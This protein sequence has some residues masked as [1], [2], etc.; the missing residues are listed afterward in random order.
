MNTNSIAKAVKGA[1]MK[2]AFQLRKH[3]PEILIV[4]GVIGTVTSAV[5]ACRAT[6]KVDDILEETRESLDKIHECTIDPELADRYTE[7]DKKKDTAIVYAQTAFKFVKL[8]GPS[9]VLGVL[10]LGSM[11]A[12]NDILRKRNIALA[13][14]YATI[15]RGFKE[16]RGRVVE[17]FG[18]EIDK[19]LRYNLK[20]VEVKEKVTDENGKTKTVTKT[21]NVLD[22]SHADYD[23]NKHSAYAKYFDVGNPYWEK[24]AEYNLMF[25]RAKQNYFNDKLKVDGYVFLNDVYK[26]LGILPTKAGQVVGWRYDPKSKTSDNYIDF[27]IYDIHNAC[28]RDFVNGYERSILL[29]FNVDGD[30]LSNWKGA[31]T[32]LG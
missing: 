27:G 13:A 6:L 28:S 17:R 4:T 2:T 21:V 20:A 8:Y 15:D 7:E 16:Y 30:I 1:F 24:D 5:L 3:S 12:S 10:S 29:D 19:Q 22:D 26:E 14:A 23:P 11:V 32:I 9:V 18:Q 25:L 31:D